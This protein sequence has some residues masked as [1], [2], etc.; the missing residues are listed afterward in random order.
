MRS[1][2]GAAA[3]QLSFTDT[4]GKT[5]STDAGITRPPQVTLTITDGTGAT[6]TVSS[7]TGSQ[8]PLSIR[9]FTCGF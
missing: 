4:G 5:D 6:A 8:P 7:A 3:T 9:L 1:P 2:L